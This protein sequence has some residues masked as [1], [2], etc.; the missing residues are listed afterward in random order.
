MKIIIKIILLL[1]LIVAV[2]VGVRTFSGDQGFVV[3]LDQW[4]DQFQE[5][6]EDHDADGSDDGEEEGEDDDDV[7]SRVEIHEGLPAVK[8]T[9]EIM[10]RSGIQTSSLQV[11]SHLH[12]ARATGLV[13]D[14]QPLLRKRTDYD[15]AG[16]EL[17]LTEESIRASTKV[18][19]RLRVLHKERANVSLRQVEEARFRMAE[20]NARKNSAGK[21]M[22]NIRTETLQEW[23]K[24]LSD[25]ALGTALGSQEA[26][27]EQ[28]SYF[29]R[30]LQKQDVLIMV[31]LPPDLVLPEETSFVFINTHP[32]R[33][34][35]RKA[36]LI[37]PASHTNPLSQGVTYYFRTPAENMRIGMHLSAWVIVSDEVQTGVD[38]PLA[39]VIWYG[40][41][42]WVYVQVE[43]DLYSRRPVADYRETDFGWFITNTFEQDEKIV[44]RGG[45]LL[46]SEE[47]RWQIPDEDDD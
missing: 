20:D 44:I 40:G 22:Q 25:W 34:T 26:G 37:S 8:L 17:V 36:Y 15:K 13:V 39:S 7:P 1:I 10:S 27:K 24:E 41:Q 33:S 14:F 11:V 38:V 3:A 45:Q 47:L 16:S 6:G 5:Q 42:P 46:L 18:Y 2:F 30:L 29:D 9:E 43:D 28:S 32:E 19:E 31:T 21:L 35:S 4:L 23:G 12:E